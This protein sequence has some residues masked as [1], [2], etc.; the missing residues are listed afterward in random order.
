MKIIALS[1]SHGDMYSVKKI[2]EKHKDA[3][4]IIH[5]GD[6]TRDEMDD[7]RLLYK[8][9]MYYIVRGNCDFRGEYPSSICTD[10]T[11][12]KFFITHGHLYNVKYGL[13]NLKLKAEE[14]NAKVV[15]F[16]HTHTALNDYDNG[17]Y[18]I[19]PGSCHGRQGTYAIIEIIDN[20]ILS[21]ILKVQE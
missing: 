5:C 14:E 9:K 20:S 17:I 6:N 3:D 7:I 12:V 1:D 4:I 15:L 8:D 18:F 16:G 11:D 13:L 10:I 2:I 19:N 21:R